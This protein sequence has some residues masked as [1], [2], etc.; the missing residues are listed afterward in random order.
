MRDDWF[1]DHHDDPE[2]LHDWLI[3][4]GVRDPERGCRD[5]R[6]LAEHAGPDCMDLTARI[7]VQLDA[8]LPRCPE[9]GM[10]LANLERFVAARPEPVAT[11]RKLAGNPKTTEILLQVFSTSQHLSELL[12][13]DP[14]LDRLAARRRGAARPGGPDRRSLELAPRGPH[15]ERAVAGHPPLP[16]PRDSPDRLQRHRPR[17]PH[18]G[19]HGRPVESR[20]R[21]HGGRDPAGPVVGRNRGSARPAAATGSRPDSSCWDWASSGEPS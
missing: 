6:D 18:G 19:D 5:L 20:R 2:R 8:V 9:P 14:A 4:V 21:L 16:A 12:I 10:A 13:R 11:L 1:L 3:S 17:V 15:R 7:V